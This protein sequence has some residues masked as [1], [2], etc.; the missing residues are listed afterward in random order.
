[1]PKRARSTAANR[2][3]A[4]RAKP[5]IYRTPLTIPDALI[6]DMKFAQNLSLSSGVVSELY[7]TFRALSIYDPWYTGAGNQ[8]YGHDSYANLYGRY[9]VKQVKIECWAD[10]ASTDTALFGLVAHESLSGPPASFVNASETPTSVSTMLGSKN[11]TPTTKKL[12]L[13]WFT[14]EAFQGDSG[15]KFDMDYQAAFGNNPNKDFGL[16][17]YGA[18]AAGNTNVSMTCYLI[19]TY[20]VQLKDRKQQLQS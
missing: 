2:Q 5:V 12:T 3:I 4:K 10:N 19:I 8:P 18:N 20:K 11:G 14:P 17:V 16:T 9:R 13:G 7:S 15:A 1:M 6:V